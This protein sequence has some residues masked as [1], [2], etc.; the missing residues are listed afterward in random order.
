MVHGSSG[1]GGVEGDVLVVV[2]VV[3]MNESIEYRKA[4][5]VVVRV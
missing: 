4:R 5:V 1:G 3:V 2:V